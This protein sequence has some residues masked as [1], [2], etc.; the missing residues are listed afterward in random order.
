MAPNIQSL[1][2]R[3][4]QHAGTAEEIDFMRDVARPL[5]ALVIAEMLA[6]APADQESF[7]AGSDDIAAFIGSPTPTQEIARVAQ[8]S[9]VALNEYFRDLLPQRRKHPGADLISQLIPL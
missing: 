7:V 3:L 4:L 2:D 9:L 8:S 5:P 1:V 6:I